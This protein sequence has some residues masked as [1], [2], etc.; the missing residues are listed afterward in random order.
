MGVGDFIQKQFPNE[1]GDNNVLS[2]GAGGVGFG[3]AAGLVRI[4]NL[5]AGNAY[6]RL[7]STGPGSTGDTLLS[8]GSVL[9]VGRMGAGISG[10][11]YASTSTGLALS[12]GAWG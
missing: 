5:G 11:G 8:S 7:R 9:E 12:V 10:F 2:S 1:Y 3:F 6:I 4:Q